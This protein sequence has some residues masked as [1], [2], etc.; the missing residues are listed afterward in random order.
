ML[1]PT[2]ETAWETPLCIWVREQSC[3]ITPG[4]SVTFQCV[5]VIIRVNV[6]GKYSFVFVLCVPAAACTNHVPVITTLLRGG[7]TSG[8]EP[9]TSSLLESNG[10]RNSIMG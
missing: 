4:H 6:Q 7:K 5:K 2:S 3:T 8:K 1:T 10:K 9:H